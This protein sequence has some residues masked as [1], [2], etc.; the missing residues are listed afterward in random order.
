MEGELDRVQWPGPVGPAR[1]DELWK[2]TC[3]EAFVQPAA[4]PAYTEL[5]FSPSGEWAA[6][7]FD[8]CRQGMRHAPFAPVFSWRSPVLRASVDLVDTL[9]DWR[10]NLAAVIEAKDGTKSY[11]ALAHAPG[12]PDFHNPDCFI[13]T[14]PAPERS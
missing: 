10:L 14:L 11:W 6:Y 1:A 9:A 7:S 13:A 8:A 12:P 3:F 2:H 5:N 4:S